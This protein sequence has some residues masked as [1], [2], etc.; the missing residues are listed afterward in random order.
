MASGKPNQ[1]LVNFERHTS[2]GPTFAAR[3]LGMPYIS[4]AQCRSGSRVLKLHHE[5]HIQVLLL[6]DEEILMQRI[7]EVCY[8]ER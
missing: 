1:I 4:Y 6:L 7:N 5:F 3:L 8:G 2:L